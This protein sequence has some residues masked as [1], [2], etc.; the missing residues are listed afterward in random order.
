M[1]IGS[2]VRVL[3]HVLRLAIV[4]K[5]GASDPVETLVVAP[6]NDFIQS[7]LAAADAIDNLFVGPAFGPRLLKNLRSFH[8]FLNYRARSEERVTLSF[9]LQ[10]TKNL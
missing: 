9:P 2:H 1:L 7:R 5:N 3:H 10:T 8:S 6:H 4:A